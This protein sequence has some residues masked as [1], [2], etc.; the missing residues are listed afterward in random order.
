M[1][2]TAFSP[3][4]SCCVAPSTSSPASAPPP[5][6]NPTS[7]FTSSA[8]STAS[9]DNLPNTA[10]PTTTTTT[11][12]SQLQSQ[13]ETQEIN[14]SIS[15]DAHADHNGR[16]AG[17]GDGHHAVSCSASSFVSA[18][19]MVF[20]G[21]SVNSVANGGPSA[22]PFLLGNRQHQLHLAALEHHQQFASLHHQSTT[23]SSS[24]SS[25]TCLSHNH[26]TTGTTTLGG[27]TAIGN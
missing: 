11:T 6:L 23:S 27:A 1:G 13:G 5:P 26:P 9:V 7:M 16:E 19:A 2:P 18:A 17:G 21:S 3:F 4:S 8:S 12:G 20:A 22:M 24:G 14:L 10:Q 25:P 15:P